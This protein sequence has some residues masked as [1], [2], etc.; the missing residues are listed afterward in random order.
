MLTALSRRGWIILAVVVLV[1]GAGV[2]VWQAGYAPQIGRFFASEFF[3][4]LQDRISLVSPVGGEEWTAEQPSGSVTFRV[5]ASLLTRKVRYT[6]FLQS[7]SADGS[8]TRFPGWSA[9][10]DNI[11]LG[12]TVSQ[13]L[14]PLTG[15]PVGYYTVGVEAR[16]PVSGAELAYPGFSTLPVFVTK[17]LTPPD[18]TG[19]CLWNGGNPSISLRY[20]A[21]G[22]SVPV[23]TQDPTMRIPESSPSPKFPPPPP[24]V[25]LRT[26]QVGGVVENHEIYFGTGPTYTDSLVT[27]GVTYTYGFSAAGSNTLLAPMIFVAAATEGGCGAAPFIPPPPSRTYTPTP[28]PVGSCVPYPVCVPS[29][30]SPCPVI[31]LLPGQYFCPPPSP[32]PTFTPTPIPNTPYLEIDPQL[33]TGA[34][35]PAGSEATMPILLTTGTYSVTA[36]K[37]VAQLSGNAYFAG[38]GTGTPLFPEVL[39]QPAISPNLATFTVG[40]GPSGGQSGSRLQVGQLAIRVPPDARDGDIITVLITPESQ[41]SAVGYPGNV[42]R[43]GGSVRLTVVSRPSVR[44]DADGNGKVD[45]FDYNIVVSEFGKTG[46]GLRGD[47]NRD[48]KVD[49]FDYNLVISNFGR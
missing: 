12:N 42:L 37:V 13:P 47:V 39:V 6:V 20:D 46:P 14:P 48:G 36:V 44:G 1:V 29:P 9:V 3:V 5:P 15:V 23:P 22:L 35:V 32:T 11:V 45:I 21:T 49:I 10:I 38:A 28:T 30:A 24:M 43:S 8:S 41:V 16:D 18:I 27:P 7:V 25:I 34:N 26:S 17:A 19:R 4:S 33:G 31:D 2:W 40:S